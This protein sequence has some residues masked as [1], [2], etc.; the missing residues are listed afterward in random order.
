MAYSSITKPEDHFETKL[1]AG[2]S[3]NVT[4]SGLNFQPD[5]IWLKNRSATDNHVVCDAVRGGNS[6]GYGNLYTNL[7]DV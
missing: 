7:S 4:V 6:N 1:Y 2:S 5:F 3:S